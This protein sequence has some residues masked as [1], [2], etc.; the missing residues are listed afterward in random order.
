MKLLLHIGPPKT[1]STS[2]QYALEENRDRLARAGILQF[3]APGGGPP[4][5]ALG[6]RFSADEALSRHPFTRRFSGPAEVRDWSA[7]AWQALSA[8]VAQSDADLCIL[9]S[10]HFSYGIDT[11]AFVAALSELFSDITVIAYARDPLSFYHS[12]LQQY[13][14][15]AR[16]L[17]Q[18]PMPA[19][20]SFGLRRMVETYADL[21]GPGQV[22]LRNFARTNL[23]DGDVVRDFA[24]Q[25]A[26]FGKTV[27]IAAGP[28]RNEAV[29]GAL[30]ALLLFVNE[31]RP[32]RTRDPYRVAFL[33]RMA[34]SDRVAALPAFRPDMPWIAAQIRAATAEDCAWLNQRFL[35]G[36]EPLAVER[37]DMT[38]LPGPRA[39]R[40]QMR[41]AL[42]ACLTPE[43]LAVLAREGID[44]N[45]VGVDMDAARPQTAGDMT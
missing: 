33:K 40:A 25:L 28:R 16:P 43:A 6:A 21:I 10:E 26:R 34:Q 1:G 22:I 7:L 2:I 29:P 15:G 41:D 44:I 12:R 4:L 36:Q 8:Q 42:T 39:Q 13:L 30:M 5:R 32:P 45:G 23:V 20:F 35:G 17:A 19:D 27:D 14:R 24:A 31:A 18:L 11:P 37:P 38:G 3:T 9:S